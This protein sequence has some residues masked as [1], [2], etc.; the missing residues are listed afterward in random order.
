M[1]NIGSTEL[2]IN[3][4]RLPLEDF[5]NYSTKLFDEWE[6]YVRDN[7]ALSDFYLALEV[8][9]GSIITK[10]KILVTTTALCGFL[11][12]YGA[13]SSGVKNLYSDVIAVGDYLGLRATEALPDFHGK[14]RIRNRG[15]ALSKLNTLF[16]KVSNGSMSHEE[17][18]VQAGRILGVDPNDSP[19]FMEALG[20]SFHN[21][22]S[23]ILLPLE[24]QAVSHLLDNQENPKNP[25]PPSKKAPA[26]RP[27]QYRVEIWRES[28]NSQRKVVIKKL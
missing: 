21:I 13:I 15:E 16:I 5:K 27:E 1:I 25:K 17:A 14:P 18:T 28:K 19:E 22:P 8:Q 24:T 7:L 23:Q 3:V 2:Y 6:E 4:E 9:E 11:A 12:S 20:A 10:S 26:I